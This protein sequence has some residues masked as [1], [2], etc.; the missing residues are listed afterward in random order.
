MPPTLTVANTDSLGEQIQRAFPEAKVVKSLT[1]VY[2]E[3]MVDPSRIAGEHTIFV[4][5]ND[6]TAKKTVHAILSAFGWPDA[7]ILDLG[8]ITGARAVEMY[9]RLFF[10]LAAKRDTFEVNIHVAPSSR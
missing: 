6:E 2:C 5:G 3:V 7:S 9:S 1:T 10:T 8:D 4:A